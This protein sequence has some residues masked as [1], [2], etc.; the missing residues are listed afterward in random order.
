MGRRAAAAGDTWGRMEPDQPSEA[1]QEGPCAV[2]PVSDDPKVTYLP[3]RRAKG[4]L[5][6]TTW[7]KLRGGMRDKAQRVKAEQK[8]AT[9]KMT[10]LPRSKD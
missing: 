1:R 3:A 9:K 4:A 6:A 5:D 2:V 10:R 8:G 7:S